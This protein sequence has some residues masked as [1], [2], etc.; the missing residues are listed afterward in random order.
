MA[1]R[2]DSNRIRAGLATAVAAAF[3]GAL[4]PATAAA[5]DAYVDDS[6]GHAG[7]PCTLLDPCSSINTGIGQA[8][9]GAT[10]HVDGGTYAQNVLLGN[11]KS[12]VAD[13]F[14]ADG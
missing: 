1:G 4:A 11:G 5:T 7:A 2:H 8:T 12:L 10:V 9:T 3:L 14:D 13:D 6:S